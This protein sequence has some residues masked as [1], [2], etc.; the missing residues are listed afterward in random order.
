MIHK[1]KLTSLLLLAVIGL[2]TLAACAGPAGTASEQPRTISVTGNG[3]AY[4]KPDTAV[5]SIGVQTRNPDPG[6]AVTENTEKMN[7]IIAALKNLGIE[8]KDIQTANFSVYANQNYDPQTGQPTTIEYVADNTVSVTIRDLNKVG[9]ALGKAVDAG[10]N[11][12]YGVSFT[13]SDQSALEATAREKAMADAKARAEQ[14]AKAAG[15]TL[16]APMSISEYT[17]G[18]VPYYDVRAADVGLGGGAATV[19]VQGGQISV[20][21]QVNVT[22]I[23][24]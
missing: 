23:I 11:S 17:S 15:V 2:F 5:A 24:K 18:P 16:D 7:S 4:G 10:A 21:L 3:I 14:L 9:E 12:I 22:Y 8:E 6:K 1:T 20:T 19:P 13:V